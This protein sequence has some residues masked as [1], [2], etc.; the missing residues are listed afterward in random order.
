MTLGD[1]V[2]VMRA[3]V[4]QQVGSPAELYDQPRNLFV[5]GF[6]G[7]PA[8]NFMP[9]SW[10]AASCGCRSASSR[11]ATWPAVAARAMSSSGCGRRTSRMPRSSATRQG[12]AR[13]RL[14]GRDRPGRVARLRPLRLL[15]RRVRGR[16]VRP[17]RRPG[18]RPA[19]RDRRRSVC[20][21]ARS[22]SSRGSSRPAA[23]AAVRPAQLWADTAKLHLFDPESGE[24]LGSR[25]RGGGER[26]PSA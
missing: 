23:S 4:L 22:R 5:A 12:R 6:I 7:S 2:A 24:R 20:A 9:G 25:P 21:R 8:M 16:P 3:G 19:R 13:A 26:G 10:P 18:R 1:R 17:A 14:R 11:P 15:P